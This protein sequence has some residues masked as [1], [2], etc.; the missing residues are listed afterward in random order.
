MKPRRNPPRRPALRGLPALWLGLLLL[1]FPSGVA[2]AQGREADLVL[3]GEVRR[4][5][6]QTFRELPFRVP[7]GVDRL[8]VE[9]S[10]DGGATKTVL[11]LGVRDPTRFRGWSGGARTGFEIG[12]SGAT[13]GYLPGPLPPGRWRVVLGIPNVR[14][15]A[16]ARYT[17][18]IWFRR[19]GTGPDPAF[20]RPVRETAGWYRGDLHLHTGHSDGRCPSVTGQPAPCP[21]FLTFEAARAAGLDFIALS[22]HNTTSQAG[23]LAELSAHF[24]DLLVLPAREVTTFEGHANV[25]GTWAPL[26]FRLGKGDATGLARLLDA[27]EGEGALVAPN[28]PGLPSGEVCMGCGWSATTDWSRIPALEVVSGGVPALGMDGAFSGLALWNRLLDQGRRVT[29]IAGS[30]THDPTRTDP[31]SPQVGRPATVVFARSLGVP[32]ILAGIRSGRVFLDLTGNRAARLDY[33]ARTRDGRSA[34]MGGEL[35]LAPGEVLDVTVT[36]AGAGERARLRAVG[37][38]GAID[39]PLPPGGEV[40]LEGLAAPD[41]ASWFRF[42]VVGPGGAR[43]L[44]GN[45]VYVR[46]KP[47][48]A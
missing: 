20:E 24:D 17:V 19:P 30:D 15:D 44:I 13:P 46:L 21:A 5:D 2:L 37:G 40:R 31:M 10:H 27:A 28:H 23:A 11:D 25:Y 26:D 29:G 1:L 42:E 6:H 22:E 9:L 34:A 14:P 7:A 18:R 3:R 41:K 43:R 39:M 35:S 33:V 48:G 8:R 32:D 47:P 45:P 4:P 12:E 36:A 38:I 16:V